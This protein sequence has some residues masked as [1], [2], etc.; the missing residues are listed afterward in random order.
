MAR[1]GRASRCRQR[2]IAS[3]RSGCAAWT[4]DQVPTEVEPMMSRSRIGRQVDQRVDPPVR[5]AA[6]SPRST[7]RAPANARSVSSRPYQERPPCLRTVSI[8]CAT[9]WSRC[10]TVCSRSSPGSPATACA[11]AA[12]K[13]PA[14]TASRSKKRRV[15]L[16][17]LLVGP[18]DRGVE[19]AVPVGTTCAGAGEHVE[20]TI[21]MGQDLRRGEGPGA[22]RSQLDRQRQPVEA[23]AQLRDG[24]CRMSVEHAAP[25]RRR[26]RGPAATPRQGSRAAAPGRR[27]WAG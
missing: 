11:A 4:A 16:G 6:S 25:R 19:A 26:G 20:P 1:S 13:R 10:P 9:S 15:A 2:R 14:N 22:G 8:E 23:A 21:Q 27:L 3:R 7:S 17:S 24:R 12:V 5:T 18:A